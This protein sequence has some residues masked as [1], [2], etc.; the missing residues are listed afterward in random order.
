VTNLEP[1][2]KRIKLERNKKGWTL[3]TLALQ[4]G[5]TSS[6]LSQIEK[7][8]AS[9]SIKSLRL[10]S[11]ALDVPMFTF[12]LE[13]NSNDA[14]VVRKNQRKIISNPKMNQVSYELLSPDL[15]SDIEF[16]LMTVPAG[17][18]SSDEL[19]EHLGEEAAFVMKGTVHLELEAEKI[20]LLQGD[21]VKIPKR[22]KHRWVNHSMNDSEIIFAITP[23]SF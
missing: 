19:M 20:E 21:S 8:K 15:K 14:L 4:V 9:P 1:I 23:P 10:I 6:L 5:I 7:G 22:V 16:A 12:F 13:E 11:Q 2:G 18:V 17:T 3:N